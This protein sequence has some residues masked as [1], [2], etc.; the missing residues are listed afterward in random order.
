MPKANGYAKIAKRILILHSRANKLQADLLALEALVSTEAKK[1]GTVPANA[2][3]PLTLKAG[4]GA[5]KAAAGRTA[6]ARPAKT[7]SIS[8]AMRTRKP[9]AGK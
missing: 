1:V 8:A 7:A 9:S 6:P 3:K 4:A 5:R 2:K